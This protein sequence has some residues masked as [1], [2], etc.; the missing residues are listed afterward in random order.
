MAVPVGLN[1]WSRLVETTFPYLDRTAAPFDA[2][3]FPDH[4][5]Y[6]GHKVAEGWSLLAW[7]MAR[8]PDKVCARFW[9]RTEEAAPW[10]PRS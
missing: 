9:R 7:A 8:Y 2:L 1:V 6:A 10:H 5:Q 4:V 3:W